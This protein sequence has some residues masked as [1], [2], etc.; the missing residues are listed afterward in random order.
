[1]RAIPRRSSAIQPGR[2]SGRR[3]LRWEGSRS[4]GFEASRLVCGFEATRREDESSRGGRKVGGPPPPLTVEQR[5]GLR[6]R[7]RI[8]TASCPSC[9][10]SIRP[11]VGIR[12]ATNAPRSS[13]QMTGCN[14]Q[15]GTRPADASGGATTSSCSR[16]DYSE[17]TASVCRCHPGH[18]LERR[19]LSPGAIGLMLAVGLISLRWNRRCSRNRLRLADATGPSSSKPQRPH[20]PGFQAGSPSL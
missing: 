2:P 16:H 6:G 8:T 13:W 3:D 9:P 1:M 15:S 17:A 19:G 11:G 20:G 10:Q 12:P 18:N 5:E 7:R 4:F 14:S